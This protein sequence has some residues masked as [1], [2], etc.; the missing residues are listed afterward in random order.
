MARPAQCIRA[1]LTLQLE[2]RG[3]LTARELATALG[4]AQLTISRGLAR[5]GD[6]VVAL[7]AARRA[8][9]A[10]RRAVRSLGDRWPVYR[11]DAAGWAGE[12]ARV[13]ALHGGFLVDWAGAAP[14]WA[15]RALDREG[16]LDGFPF[17]LGD[18]RPQGFLGRQQARRVAEALR[19]P[20]DP[21]QWGD[22]DTLVF[23][24]A[25]GADLP[26]DLI[27]GEAP[28]RRLLAWALDAASA[29]VD[30]VAES[31][32]A[33]RYPE[34]PTQVSAG[35]MA[36]S[37]AG[38]EPPKFLTTVRR[39]AGSVEPVLVKFSPP[40]E[41]PVGRRWADLLAAEAHALAQLAE[42]GLATAGARVLDAGGRRFLEVTRHDRVGARGRR[43]VLSLEA[44][45]RAFDGGGAAHD[46]VA[47]A[48]SLARAELI[49]V[50][51]VDAVRRLH[52][53]GELIGNSDMHFGNLSFWLDDARPFRVAPT[54]DMLPIA[55]APSVQG[56]VAVRELAPRPPLPRAAGMWAEVAAW[57]IEFWRRV[58]ADAA[59]SAEFAEIARRT[60][61]QVERMRGLF[62]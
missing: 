3:A 1:D 45:R 22:D 59:A 56:E 12:W 57:A 48:E 39:G 36:G 14:G 27:V 8:R 43:G 11:I 47:A 7:G 10:L 37:S 58:A 44:L 41:T 21:R 53:F 35:G 55:W 52:F 18:L 26:G 54:F 4:V 42:H 38:G 40:M 30:P 29:V 13:Q 28:V 16:F 60:G 62:A 24:Q 49:E 5:L 46:W 25:E 34:L 61:A 2:V 50:A 6:A 32:P 23:L 33:V 15:E 20:A 19:L 31:A 9:Y 17:F 51:S